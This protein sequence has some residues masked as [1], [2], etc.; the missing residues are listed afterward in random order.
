M[1]TIRDEVLEVI[2]HHFRSEAT[3]RELTERVE[4]LMVGEIPGDPDVIFYLAVLTVIQSG[5]RD[6]PRVRPIRRWLV[7]R[8]IAV[9]PGDFEV[10]DFVHD[11]RRWVMRNHWPGYLAWVHENERERSCGAVPQT[12]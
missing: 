9:E 4:D 5:L 11:G 7:T 3:R 1:T 8:G 10:A 2:N 6:Q 12:K